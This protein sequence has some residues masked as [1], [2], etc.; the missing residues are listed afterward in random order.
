MCKTVYGSEVIAKLH[1][2]IKG[3][4]FVFSEYQQQCQKLASNIKN[5]SELLY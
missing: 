2:I 1:K 4:K 3:H 5:D